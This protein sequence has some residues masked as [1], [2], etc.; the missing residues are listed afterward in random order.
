MVSQFQSLKNRVLKVNGRFDKYERVVTHN[1]W[2]K[3]EY[4]L[5]HKDYGSF[6]FD[7]LKESKV[8]IKEMETYFNKKSK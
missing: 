7:T 6:S 3:P 8:E 2:K 1:G 4:T 5:Y